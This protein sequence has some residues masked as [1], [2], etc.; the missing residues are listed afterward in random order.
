M[1]SIQRVCI[2]LFVCVC[3]S[4]SVCVCV[5]LSPCVVHV[6]D[7]VSNQ[8]R[9]RWLDESPVY[10]QRGRHLQSLVRPDSGYTCTYVCVYVCLCV[11]LCVCMLRSTVGIASITLMPAPSASHTLCLAA[12]TISF[13]ITYNL[14]DVNAVCSTPAN[15]C[16]CRTNYYGT[17]LNCTLATCAATTINGIFFPAANA[18]ATSTGDCQSS[19]R[20]TATRTCTQSTT[21]VPA[22]GTAR[23]PTGTFPDNTLVNNCVQLLC[24]PPAGVEF[25]AR[26]NETLSIG[27]VMTGYC[28]ASLGYTGTIQRFCTQTGTG[29]AAVA[30]LQ[31][32]SQACTAIVCPGLS[33]PDTAWPAT[34][35]GGFNRVVNGTCALGYVP[36]SGTGLPSRTCQANGVW[37]DTITNAC[38]KLQCPSL[39]SDDGAGLAAYAAVPWSSTPVAGTCP[40]SYTTGSGG[41]APT[42]VCTIAG[43][44][45]AE[46]NPCARIQC[47]ALPAVFATGAAAFAAT[48]AGPEGGSATVVSGTCPAGWIGA[49]TR[50]CTLAANG[51]KVGLWSPAEIDPCIALACPPLDNEDNAAWPA[52]FAGNTT[53]Y[54]VCKLG[55]V[56]LPLP[57]RACTLDGTWDT[58]ILNRCAIAFCPSTAD[59]QAVSWPQTVA[60]AAAF[61]NCTLG[62]RVADLAGPPSRTCLLNGTWSDV[63]DNPCVPRVCPA[64]TEAFANWTSTNAATTAVPTVQVF[65]VCLDGFQGQAARFCN[66]SGLWTDITGACVPNECAG[67]PDCVLNCTARAEFNAVWPDSPSLVATVTGTCV[68]GWAGSPTRPCGQYGAWQ[69]PT[70]A[71]TQLACPLIS[72]ERTDTDGGAQWPTALS[73]TVG[74]TGT[75]A[76][77]FQLGPTAAAPSRACTTNCSGGDKSCAWGPVADACVPILCPALNATL[78][79]DWPTA[80]AGTAVVNGTCLPGYAGQPT[81]PCNL[82]GSWGALSSACVQLLCPTSTSVPSADDPTAFWPPAPAGTVAVAGSCK[83]LY[84]V[85]D[86]TGAARPPSRDCRL[87]G[88]WSPTVNDACVPLVCPTVTEALAVY[89]AAFAGTAQVFGTCPLG[90]SGAPRRACNDL[91][92]WGTVTGTPC[93][94][95]RCSAETLFN[96]VWPA[97]VAAN[98]TAVG[99]CVA[100]YAPTPNAAP[101]RQCQLDGLWAPALVEGAAPCAQLFCPALADD[102]N[103][104]WAAAAAGSA[105]QGVCQPT[106]AGSVQRGCS[107]DASW[108]NITGVCVPLFCPAQA[109]V[110]GTSFPAT[111]AGT[112]AAGTCLNA[113][114]AGV[115]VSD[116]SVTGIWGPIRSPCQRV[117]STCA[118]DTRGFANAVWPETAAG[119]TSAGLCLSGFATASVARL[120]LRRCVRVDDGLASYGLWDNSSIADPCLFQ[121]GYDTVT[122][123]LAGLAV[124]ATTAS[125]LTLAWT[126]IGGATIYY[127]SFSFNALD[128]YPTGAPVLVGTGTSGNATVVVSNLQEDTEYQFRVV[129]ADTLTVDV[130]GAGV[131][132]RTYIRPAAGLTVTE[133]SP[134]ALTLTWTN[135]SALTVFYRLVITPV[136]T[137]ATQRR[138]AGGG[139]GVVV[140]VQLN[141]TDAVNGT[142]MTYVARD[143]TPSTTYR[144]AVFA[145]NRNGSVETVGITLTVRTDAPPADLSALTRSNT[146]L[147][148]GVVGVAVFLVVVVIVGYMVHRRQLARKQKELLTEYHSQV[149]MLTL[150]RAPSLMAPSSFGSGSAPS[151]P[152]FFDTEALK[153]DALRANLQVPQTQFDG[154]RDTMLNTVMEVALPGFLTLDYSSDLRPEAR[155]TAGGAG[156][157]FRGELLNLEAI[158]R[159]NGVSACAIKLVADWPSLSDEANWEQFHH[160]VSVL[161]SL[162]FHANIVKLLGYTQEPRTIVTKLYPTDLFRY[163]H[164][165]QDKSPLESHL[166]LHL[167]S[168]MVAAVATVH[169]VGVA[170]RDLKSPNV[171][172]QEPRAG[173]PFPDPI[174]CDF[175]LARTTYVP[176]ERVYVYAQVCVC[177]PYLWLCMAVF[178]SV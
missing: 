68:A 174:L 15:A 38:V 90:Y 109:S 173:S 143:L 175:G 66:S 72:A 125:S 168:G 160:E 82:D 17:G 128:F 45:S 165:Q 52:A 21:C 100:G 86:P 120:P 148:G 1:E 31:P 161:W 80:V 35:T 97:N 130:A 10:R 166:M 61:G 122:V 163:L 4:L 178:Q 101:V 137:G 79:A 113:F 156:T 50:T 49:P 123:R 33:N 142:T 89:A 87:D 53:V 176:S 107:I 121:P 88:T 16:A 70:A 96:A 6:A 19:F 30:V 25:F 44:W 13:D 74:V 11:C 23:C 58:Q 60:G 105:A 37:A 59:Y 36:S 141:A 127:V 75:C 73:G 46:S 118:T 84:G 162:S 64:L 124:T 77:G 146:I 9:F 114:E 115:P 117:A 152:N 51:T 69:P 136:V 91:G 83:S 56:P 94:L 47:P 71:C 93:T 3:V 24:T 155:L 135:G 150:Q 132:A 99:T 145:G 78:L 134:T 22:P 111:R 171:L 76:L 131:E 39:P 20:G 27:A 154:V 153:R 7:V 57:Q 103:A 2:C 41:V 138:A 104:V 29:N 26:Y 28:D 98:A 158:K 110:N 62:Y 112:S 169:A 48:D 106:F 177:V 18:G 133:Y 12:C 172:L 8:P 167:C 92:V 116:C 34:A 144:F 43:T 65:G 170:H 32:P 139:D 140:E 159:N 63:V 157:L 67:L 126:P 85:A 151:L 95:R 81:R 55:Y 102:G 108:G 129:P 54:G 149:A 40:S 147:I 119:G 42:R 5:R 164:G 14:C